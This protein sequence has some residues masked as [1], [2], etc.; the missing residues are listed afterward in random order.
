[1]AVPD[2]RN[3]EAYNINVKLMSAIQR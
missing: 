2:G 1:V 3:L